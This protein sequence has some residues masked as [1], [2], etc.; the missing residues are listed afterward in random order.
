MIP[1]HARGRGVLHP[2]S[3]VGGGWPGIFAPRTGLSPRRIRGRT[4]GYLSLRPAGRR[5]AGEMGG[6]RRKLQS[7]AEPGR[8]PR[9]GDAPSG[10]SLSLNHVQGPRGACLLPVLKSLLVSLTKNCLKVLTKHLSCGISEVRKHR[11]AS[12]P[13]RAQLYG[14]CSAR[15]EC[16]REGALAGSWLVHFVSLAWVSGKAGGAQLPPARLAQEKGLGAV[17]PAVCTT[18]AAFRDAPDPHPRRPQCSGR[19]SSPE[20]C[21]PRAQGE[22]GMVS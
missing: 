1:R 19:F 18:A 8:M 4:W 20:P 13:Q 11:A 5:A 12:K 22:P 17:S 21:L 14:S 6:N 15:S 2:L 9:Q 7:P 3:S 10:L 16:R